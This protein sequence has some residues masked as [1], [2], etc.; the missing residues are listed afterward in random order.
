MELKKINKTFKKNGF[1]FKMLCRN[2]EYVIYSLSKPNG[3][4][5]NGI[6]VSQKTYEIHK[7]R[8]IPCNIFVTKKNENGYTHY[9]KLAS[10][11]DFGKYGWAYSKLEH[12]F[13]H[14]PKMKEIYKNYEKN[15]IQ[16][17]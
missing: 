15:G 9:E 8:V 11:E 1:N 10:N 12:I 16:N 5:L 3:I 6:G 2:K 13:K 7:I 14:F 17:N 4:G